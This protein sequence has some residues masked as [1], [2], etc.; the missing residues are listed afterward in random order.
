MVLNL[1]WKMRIL[2]SLACID[3]ATPSAYLYY[4]HLLGSSDQIRF[5]YNVIILYALHLALEK[6]RKK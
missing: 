3:T 2:H 5:F 4:Y 6:R 1:K